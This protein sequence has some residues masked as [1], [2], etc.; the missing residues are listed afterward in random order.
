M[1]SLKG[2]THEQIMAETDHF[3]KEDI[4]GEGAVIGRGGNDGPECFLLNEREFLLVNEFEALENAG[5][6][7]KQE[8]AVLLQIRAVIRSIEILGCANTVEFPR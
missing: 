8:L 7:L 1:K 3:F 4:S 5:A 2:L 6:P